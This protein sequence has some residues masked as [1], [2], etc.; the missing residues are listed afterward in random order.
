MSVRHGRAA[1][2]ALEGPGEL[3]MMQQPL[4]MDMA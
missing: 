3:A 4:T 1:A 2:F